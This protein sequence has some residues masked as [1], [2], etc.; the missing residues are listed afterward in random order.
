MNSQ[1]LIIHGCPKLESLLCRMQIFIRPTGRKHLMPISTSLR[2][3]LCCA[4]VR[5]EEEEAG[6]RRIRPLPQ[7]VESGSGPVQAGPAQTGR[8]HWGYVENEV[9]RMLQEMIGELE[10][11]PEIKKI[12]LPEHPDP[13]HPPAYYRIDPESNRPVPGK[14][15]L[16]RGDYVYVPE[17]G[18]RITREEYIPPWRDP[19][20]FPT[21]NDL[22]SRG[23]DA[24]YSLHGEGA[25]MR[26]MYHW[27]TGL[28]GE[29]GITTRVDRL[30]SPAVNT[31]HFSHH[32]PART[33][34]PAIEPVPEP[35]RQPAGRAGYPLARTEAQART[36]SPARAEAPSI[37]P[38]PA[39]VRQ[40]ADT[41]DSQRREIPLPDHPGP[42]H[43]RIYYTVDPASGRPIPERDS[44][45]RG[46]YVR[47]GP[48][49]YQFIR[50]DILPL[51][52]SRKAMQS[53]GVHDNGAGVYY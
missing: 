28:P 16:L 48:R 29:P 36:E 37:Q 45:I 21:E 18:S 39:P 41:A 25:G 44:Y 20:V 35:N 52:L 51:P 32:P 22:M 17:D 4:P 13:Q 46:N 7:P 42:R 19:G 14:D 31:M 12:P 33:E 1:F 2:K 5:Q 34:V 24:C 23:W 53:T 8:P 30:F 49:P 15:A 9:D 50:G 47:W 38:V 27:L 10:K 11:S 26:L 3:L 43:P 40:P 6:A